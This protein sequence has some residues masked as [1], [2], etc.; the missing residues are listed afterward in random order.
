MLTPL[1]SLLVVAA[2]LLLA[3]LLASPLAGVVQPVRAEGGQGKT[4]DARPP[5]M[6]LLLERVVPGGKQAIGVYGITPEV[7]QPGLFRVKLWDETPNN[8]LVRNETIRCTPSEPL[9]VTSD[10]RRIFLRKLNPGGP[11]TP[12]NRID[13]LIW[14]AT[15]FPDQA[16]KDPANLGELARKLGYGGGI[17]ESELVLPG[18]TRGDR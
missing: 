13:H 6:V 5:G 14:W 18:G 17:V 10:G 8:V 4:E 1:R 16:G 12:A 15:C 2:P 11:V 7:A 3:P 9:R